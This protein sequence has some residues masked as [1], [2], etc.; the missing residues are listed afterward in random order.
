MKYGSK[1][2]PRSHC[3]R[4]DPIS[5]KRGTAA[6]SFRPMSIVD[7]VAH[8]SCCWAL[9]TFISAVL[10]FFV[11]EFFSYFTFSLITVT[12][13]ILTATIVCGGSV[14][15]RGKLSSCCWDM[16]CCSWP[17]HSIYSI[18]K[19]HIQAHFSCMHSAIAAELIQTKF[20]TSS[21]WVDIVIYLKQ[22]LNCLRVLEGDFSLFGLSHWP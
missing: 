6:P 8:L 12:F 18:T 17:W 2:R 1:P 16:G 5:C 22:H 3:T 10:Y 9:V 13:E 21:P 11:F 19:I 15:H 20:C 4:R 14:H 7:M